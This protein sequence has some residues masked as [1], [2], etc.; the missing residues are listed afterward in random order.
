MTRLEE[1]RGSGAL[2]RLAS[3]WAGLLGAVRQRWT[4]ADEVARLDDREVADLGLSRTELRSVAQ[5]GS[6]PRRLMTAMMAR[7]G[8]RPSDLRRVPGLMREVE[9]NCASCADKRRCRRWLR[10]AEPAA[11]YRDFCPNA[12]SFDR[13]LA[14]RA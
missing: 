10:S 3:G 7:V 6:R 1:G 2:A 9:L 4:L 13:A 12:D 5:A 14:K 8:V 11:T